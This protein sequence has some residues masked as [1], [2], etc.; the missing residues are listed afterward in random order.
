MHNFAKSS[1]AYQ[2]GRNGKDATLLLVSTFNYSLCDDNYC[3]SRSHQ[4]CRHSLL[5]HL[6]T[7][8]PIFDSF[9]RIHLLIYTHKQYNWT[10]HQSPLHISLLGVK[11][12]VQLVRRSRIFLLILDCYIVTR[13]GC[14]KWREEKWIWILCS[15]VV[16]S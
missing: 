11:F 1:G 10:L 12:D 13:V 8:F 4:R 14:V 3:H 16:F 15:K 2:D 9:V 7:S 5:L 6:T